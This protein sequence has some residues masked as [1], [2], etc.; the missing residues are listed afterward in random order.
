MRPPSIRNQKPRNQRDRKTNTGAENPSIFH[1][2]HS[3]GE[4]EI[5]V[6]PIQELCR[7]I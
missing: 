5:A 7:A 1:R 6:M 4:V 2:E 3:H